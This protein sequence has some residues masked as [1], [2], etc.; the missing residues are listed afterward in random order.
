MVGELG[1]R[2]GVVRSLM[3]WGG[4]LFIV[5]VPL[6]G[7]VT[8]VLICQFQITLR[9]V[10]GKLVCKGGA[11]ES[12]ARVLLAMGDGRICDKCCWWSAWLPGGGGNECRRPGA[13]RALQ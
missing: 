3:N 4:C 12:C 13:K 2:G 1:R 11:V 10:V 9:V 5:V 7:A 8:I 6:L